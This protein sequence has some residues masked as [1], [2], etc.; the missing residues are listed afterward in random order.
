MGA[1]PVGLL[2]IDRVAIFTAQDITENSMDML[3]VDGSHFITPDIQLAGTAF[4][5]GNDT[6]S[7]NG[8][9]SEFGLCE[10]SG[11][12]RSLF[13]GIEEIEKSLEDEL[14]IALED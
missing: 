3:S 4:W 1:A 6:D 8:D 9:A 5:R 2:A 13:A 11:G 7:F 10:Y 14:G 12:A